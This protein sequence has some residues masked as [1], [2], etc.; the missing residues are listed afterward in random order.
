MFIITG[1]PRSGTLYTA[2]VLQ[3]LGYDV[4]HER[5]SE[6]GTVDWTYPVKAEKYPHPE[7]VLHQVREPLAT[8]ASMQTLQRDSW[9]CI[10]KNSRVVS[11]WPLLRRC[12]KVWL[13]WNLKTESLAS[14]SYRIEDLPNVWAEW[15]ERLGVQGEYGQVAHLPHT[16]HAREHG[17]VTW[18]D[19]EKA[20]PLAG[21]IKDLARRYG[22]D[23]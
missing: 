16:I 19:V 14:W 2:K 12:A 17:P 7:V 6:V 21:E 11:G 5:K 10:S 8:I 9:N 22:Y 13:Y 15:C 1:C 20:T 3:T 23:C 4:K 18:A